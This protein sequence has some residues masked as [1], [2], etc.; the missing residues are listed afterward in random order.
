M[1][2]CVHSLQFGAIRFVGISPLVKLTR[3]II[4]VF[5][6]FAT[7]LV[8]GVGLLTYQS[9]KESLQS[10]A[11]RELK[12]VAVEKEAAVK[13]LLGSRLGALRFLAGS[14]TLQQS[15]MKHAGESDPAG[16][17]PPLG[18][19]AVVK[20]FLDSVGSGAGFKDM[21]LCDAATGRVV[22]STI[23]SEEGTSVAGQ[24]V[25]EKGKIGPYLE[26]PELN[27]DPDKTRVTLAVPVL[28]T[29][30]S[31]VLG[32]LVARMNLKG[33]KD[34]VQ[35]GTG[36]RLTN[37]TFLVN[38]KG[39]VLTKPTRNS[40]AGFP[41]DAFIARCIHDENGEMTG[42]DHGGIPVIVVYRWNPELQLGLISRVDLDEAIAPARA[43]GR[44]ILTISLAALLIAFVLAEA[45]G[46]GI[47]RPLVRLQRGAALLGRGEFD[48]RLA[49][50]DPGEIGELSREFNRMAASISEM[51]EH[52]LK[53]AED[54]EQRVSDRTG[55]LAMANFELAHEITERRRIEDELR[56][57]NEWAE[58][59]NRDLAQEIELRGAASVELRAAKVAA[60]AANRAKSEF[61]ANMSHEIR[62]PMN[63]ILGMTE[64]AL[65]TALTSQ[66]R[67]CL[68]LV[69]KSG[70]ALLGIINDVLDCAKIES[71]KL[72]LEC[73]RF[74]LRELVAEALKPLGFDA[75]QKGLELVTDLPASTPDS[76]MGDPVR[77]RQ[78]LINLIGNA[79]KF[80]ETGEV[81]VAVRPG[82][83][84]NGK[85]Q[86]QFSI[87]D[88]GIG[89]AP[90]MQRSIFAAFVQ[91][92]GSST[93][94]FGGTGLGLA[95]SSGLVEQMG[96][97]LEVT[98]ELGR[99]S[100]FKFQVGFEIVA[101]SAYSMPV[102]HAEVLS[103]SRALVIDDNASSRRVLGEM[104][105]GWG[106]QTITSENGL[107]ALS[108]LRQA[109]EDGTPFDVVLAD[110][111]MS[112]MDGFA[113]AERI[114]GQPQA[115]R[116]TLIMHTTPL[117]AAMEERVR[118]LGVSAV[119]FKP[120]SEAE[121]Q[122]AV[123]ASMGVAIEAPLHVNGA[124]RPVRPL[125]ILVA[126]DN[127]VNQ[128][129]TS[130]FLSSRGHHVRMVSDGAQ[131]VAAVEDS[132]FDV[133]LM[134]VQMPEMDGFEATARIRALQR[135]SGRRTPIVALTAR[136]MK[137]DEEK[138]LLGGMDAYLSKP[139]SR[140][141][142]LNMVEGASQ[143][144][145][146]PE[147][148]NHVAISPQPLQCA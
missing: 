138:C 120:I 71:G 130:S 72:Q 97:R 32:V 64:L 12:S 123:L 1:K 125:R 73:V 26:I 81:V 47:A 17:T 66:Q 27:G 24:L 146:S 13:D 145:V 131:A 60:E 91:A 43:L 35:R 124:Q 6:L 65:D 99:G 5:V 92:D 117:L 105:S 10:A 134:D 140:A 46:R 133:I 11:I 22:V 52:L 75:G 14:P 93:R 139:F 3:Q 77:L 135:D 44:R 36:Q 111:G 56:S 30:G 7:A 144:E 76:L 96:G 141:V 128:H 116:S 86:L 88:T 2:V 110:M 50:N 95:I 136:A 55:Q 137:G 98:S 20:R 18:H 31:A 69:Q 54:L 107:E 53:N 41:S 70:Q 89:I 127:P 114:C 100:C 102:E 82:Q 85:E 129:V 67:E 37:D 29:D 113:L 119:L 23:R 101:E 143:G 108:E 9:A 68:T 109:V 49:E 59:S 94:R 115:A 90:E 4:L 63:G 74:S 84:E 45:V 40:R 121:L 79:V 38:N 104:M 39:A 33:L 112:E 126:E 122:R 78:V 87:S 61:L 57:A 42:T 132:E 83:S 8:A 103:K 142:L 118:K 15:I 28:G 58:A 51:R 148:T 48:T 62:T 19:D 16:V 80:T 25:L 147:V 106:M 34:I 21:F